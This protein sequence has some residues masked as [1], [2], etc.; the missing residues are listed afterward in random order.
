MT[1]KRH[2]KSHKRTNITFITTPEGDHHHR[3][4]LDKNL[5]TETQSLRPIL[6]ISVTVD[7]N[8][9]L[10]IYKTG[11]EGKDNDYSRGAEIKIIFDCY[12]KYD[13]FSGSADKDWN[14]YLTQCTS[15][16]NEYNAEP[17]T[18]ARHFGNFL[19]HTPLAYHYYQSL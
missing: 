5:L 19:Q 3:I 8:H 7:T 6:S 13:F 10:R 11:D 4:R 2:K 1:A 9:I 17:K 12:N 14:R 15:L 16:C 18:I